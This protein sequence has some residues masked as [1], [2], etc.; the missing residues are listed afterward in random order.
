MRLLGNNKNHIQVRKK[1]NSHDIAILRKEK[2]INDVKF[3]E[4]IIPSLNLFLLLAISASFIGIWVK[5]KKYINN[6]YNDFYN[7]LLDLDE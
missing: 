7:N 1:L 4:S 6:T 3:F 5:K 2:L